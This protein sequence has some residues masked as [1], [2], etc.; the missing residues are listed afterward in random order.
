MM[1]IT[2]EN[3]ENGLLSKEWDFGNN[4]LYKLCN[5]NFYH[6]KKDV[7]IA[8]VWLIG[9]SYAAA[10]ERRKNKIAIND[11]FYT[12]SVVPAFQNSKL[13]K[14]LNIIK[15]EHEINVG[16]IENILV[17]HNYLI[18]IIKEITEMEKRSFCSKY[19]HFHLPDLFFIYDSRAFSALRQF[20]SRIPKEFSYLTK[21]KG[22]DSE[23]ANFFVK[24]FVLRNQI[25]AEFG[26][27]LTTREFDKILIVKANNK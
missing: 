7:I 18:Q 13:D 24:C 8:K 10:I 9:R 19:L 20:I 27:K 3:I 2:K 22:I 23:Y 17:T 4:I 12:N 15:D 21:I 6:K 16:N 1:K 5:E 25:E 26:I 14:Y 11:N